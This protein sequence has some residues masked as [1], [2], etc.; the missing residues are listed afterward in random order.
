MSYQENS[1]TG[2]SQYPRSGPRSDIFLGPS[3][4]NATEYDEV[5][6]RRGWCNQMLYN[7]ACVNSKAK[8]LNVYF[9]EY[10]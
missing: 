8:I 4:N 3:E 9:G 10:V 1:P 5:I 6:D 7:V 2:Q